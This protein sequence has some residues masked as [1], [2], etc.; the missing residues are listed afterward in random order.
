MVLEATEI[1]LGRAT[2]P[3]TLGVLC[4]G[5]ILMPIPLLCVYRVSHR[6]GTSI[7]FHQA[8]DTNF[9]QPRHCWKRR[10]SQKRKWG[11]Y[12][13][14]KKEEDRI[15][16]ADLL[17]Y[18]SKKTTL[19]VILRK[20]AD[21]RLRKILSQIVYINLFPTYSYIIPIILYVPL[22]PPIKALVLVHCVGIQAIGSVEIP[23]DKSGFVAG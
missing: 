2:Y 13:H 23:S 6:T 5:R 19:S 16:T 7:I 11:I 8:R 21:N 22:F 14:S 1:G 20:I 18:A 3:H 9:G 17:S 4:I 12:R 10:Q 15:L